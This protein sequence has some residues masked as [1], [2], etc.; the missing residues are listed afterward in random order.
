MSQVFRYTPS[1]IVA[2]YA[3]SV[4]GLGVTL[5]PLALLEPPAWIGVVLTVGAALFLVHAVRSVARHTLQIVLDDSGIEARG[6][7]GV[8]IAWD[9]LRSVDVN[10]YSTH[11]D[12]SNGWTE[13]VVRSARGKIRIESTLE[14]FSGIA[15][16]VAREA[17]QRDC[18]LDDRS[19]TN[20]AALGVDLGEEAAVNI[21]PSGRA[22]H[23]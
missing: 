18:Q 5:G 8:A 21:D 20:L 23:A 13:L 15:A 12:G 4:I 14:G 3:R 10:Y 11:R 9:A 6:L 1:A 19:R 17:L 7:F 2:E 22:R 16:R